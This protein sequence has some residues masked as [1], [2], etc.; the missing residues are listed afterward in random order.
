MGDGERVI[1]KDWWLHGFK[2]DYKFN[3]VIFSVLSET[4]YWYSS[5]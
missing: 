5:L 4:G 1:G 2:I 3:E